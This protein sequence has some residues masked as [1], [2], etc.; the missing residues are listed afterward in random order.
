MKLAE[1]NKVHQADLL[2]LPHDRRGRKIYKYAL[3]VIDIASRY[4][5]AKPLESKSSNEVSKSFKKIYS[6]RLDWPETLQV[7]PGREFMGEVRNLMNKHNVKIRRSDA[8]HHTAQAFVERANRTLGE[9]IF[10]HQYAQELIRGKE[11]REWVKRLPGLIK[12][13]NSTSTRIS[14][15]KNS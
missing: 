4:K 11:S 6:R 3:V 8:G 1:P 10:S 14:R 12:H 9:K 15:C 7:D 5:D 13:M 2:F